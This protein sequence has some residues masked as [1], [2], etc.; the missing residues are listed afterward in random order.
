MITDRTYQQVA[1]DFS[2]QFETNGMNSLPMFDY[3]AD[4]GF[5]IVTKQ[6]YSYHQKDFYR[7]ELIKPFAD[8]HIISV[9]PHFDDKMQH[10]VV[11]D[12]SG[13]IFCPAEKTDIKTVYA[14]DSIVGIFR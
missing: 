8:V 14:I 2:A 10:S 9:K 12:S 7:D 6:A 11:M 4:F 5:Q 1:A 3:L 13:T